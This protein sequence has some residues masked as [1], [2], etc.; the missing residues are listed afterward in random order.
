[1]LTIFFYLLYQ[2]QTFL[3]F[4]YWFTCMRYLST[5]YNRTSRIICIIESCEILP[6]SAG[7]TS[8]T[9]CLSINLWRFVMHTSQTQALQ[10]AYCTISIDSAWGVTCDQMD[11]ISTTSNAGVTLSEKSQLV[12]ESLWQ[13]INLWVLIGLQGQTYLHV[14]RSCNLALSTS[15]C[16]EVSVNEHIRVY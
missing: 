8:G 4:F 16:W 7:V 14:I 15:N 12:Y 10:K 13:L 11:K 6:V 1:M 3:W 2:N 9:W 5:R